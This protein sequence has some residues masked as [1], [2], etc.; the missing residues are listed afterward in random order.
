MRPSTEGI[1]TSPEER[2]AV[3]V[4]YR[5]FSHRQ[6]NPRN[7]S[8]RSIN[9]HVSVTVQVIAEDGDISDEGRLLYSLSTDDHHAPINTTF[10]ISR[11]SG[12]IHLLRLLT[13][14]LPIFSIPSNGQ[15]LDRD[16]PLGRAR[17]RL[18]VAATDGLH[19][20][21][22]QVHVN[23]KDI[24]DNAPFFPHNVIEASVLE[25]ADA[26]TEVAH[27]T[28]TD[29]DDPEE[30]ANAAVTYSVDKNVIDEQSGRPIFS[31]DSATGTPAGSVGRGKQMAVMTIGL[32][33]VCVIAARPRLI[34]QPNDPHS[35]C[36]LANTAGQTQFTL[37]ENHGMQLS[38][39][40][41]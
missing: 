36:T 41:T 38:K 16:A 22:A 14:H 30:G 1:T 4:H 24:N 33:V 20:A 35:L 26:G 29:L 39:V 19:T 15:P 21:R 9:R 6:F 11:S 10:S 3:R 8:N 34:A 27:V 13:F 28:A 18:W 25:N 31:I 2:N 7:R 17:W 37:E 40:K 12:Y 32:K 23:V 5:P